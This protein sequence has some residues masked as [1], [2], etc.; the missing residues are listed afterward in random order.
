MINK[1]YHPICY[2][3]FYKLNQYTSGEFDCSIY[4]RVKNIIICN[5]FHKIEKVSSI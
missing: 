2:D 3:C 1:I 5:S 4:G